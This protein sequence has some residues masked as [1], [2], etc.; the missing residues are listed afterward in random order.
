MSYA[1]IID[2]LEKF[3]ISEPVAKSTPGGAKT[4]ENGL[5]Y[6]T[7][8]CLMSELQV[9]EK[10]KFGTVV[11]YNNKELVECSKAN[12]FKYLKKYL[13]QDV[14][15]AH[16]C[17]HPDECYLDEKNK[18]IFILEKKFQMSTGSVCE[19]IQT[20]HF[21]KWQYSRLF[22]SHQISYVYVLSD[23]FR[24]NCKAEV[25]YFDEMKI[26]YFWGSDS[27]YKTKILNFLFQ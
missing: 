11:K 13:Y 14:T 16:G 18:K 10:K 3:Y 19:K 17:K 2:Q 8:T 5:G 6:E 22:K 27:D 24:E 20:H 4:N 23:W 15:H 12:L 7:M 25:E 1:S 26:T 21:K 9:V